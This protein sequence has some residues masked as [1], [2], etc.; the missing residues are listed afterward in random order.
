MSSAVSEM[1]SNT[2]IGVLL[3]DDHTVIREALAEM[4]QTDEE[5]EVLAQA[6]NGWE[7]VDLSAR[8]RPDVVL[9]DVEMPVM[10]ADEALE[11]IMKASPRSRVV[12]LTMY[13]DVGLM[14]YFLTRG[15]TSYLV[16][17]ISSKELISTVKT[18]ATGEERVS[19]SLSREALQRA[20]EE[21]GTVLSERELEVLTF[22]S[23][24]LTNLQI[25]DSLYVTEGTV[26]RH[27]HNIYSR[28]E[29]TSRGEAVRRALSEGWIT[30]RDIV[31]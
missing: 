20:A 4:L 28:L 15:A 8:H 29:V 27:L 22:L 11:E 14:R 9:L 30:A 21:G 25:A 26:K 31:G 24:G 10:G 19:L 1:S 3:A 6:E 7:A 17:S 2:K 12:I 16:K 18:V 13:D 5:I 23:R